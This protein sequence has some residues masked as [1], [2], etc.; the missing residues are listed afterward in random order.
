[1]Q[2]D[3]EPVVSAAA[4]EIGAALDALRAAGASNAMLAGSGSCVFTLTP[5]RGRLESDRRAPRAPGELRT[6]CLRFRC[7]AGLG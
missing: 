2:N 1:M 3:F 6:V 7:H 4:P 5:D